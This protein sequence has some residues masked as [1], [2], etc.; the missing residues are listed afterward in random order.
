MAVAVLTATCEKEPDEHI[1]Y[2]IF[3]DFYD[4]KPNDLDLNSYLT[5]DV[6]YN[7]TNQKYAVYFMGY[8]EET[9]NESGTQNTRKYTYSF[10]MINYDKTQGMIITHL[11]TF[12]EVNMGFEYTFQS[13]INPLPQT[14]SY[15]KYS[16]ELE[17]TK[18][19]IESGKIRGKMKGKMG[20]APGEL[21][22][23]SLIFNFNN[24]NY[25]EVE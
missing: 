7:K 22:F 10:S 21:E 2:I 8:L 14:S 6:Q 4:K 1:D 23:N 25:T 17:F 11:S 9:F 19:E 15:S 5:C 24:I 13:D 12:A 3:E 18:F 20:G 16:F